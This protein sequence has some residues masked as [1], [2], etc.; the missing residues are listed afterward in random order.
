MRFPPLHVALAFTLIYAPLSSAAQPPTFSINDYGAVSDGK[1][2]NTDAI[3]K[4]IDAASQAGGGTVKV[5]SG[6]WLTGA[7]ELKSNVTLFLDNGSTLLMSTNPADYPVVF[8]RWEGIEC[9]NYS[10]L[11]HAN[12]AS[13]IAITGKGIIDGQGQSWWRW[14]KSAGPAQ[15]KLREMGQMNV[16]PQ[17]RVFGTPKD[18][19]RPSLIEFTYCEDV[20][21]EGVSVKNSPM[22]SIHPLYCKTVICRDLYVFSQGPNTDGIDPDSCNDVLIE[23]CTLDCGD[24]CIA[25]KSGRDADGGRVDTPC[26]NIIIKDCHMQ[27]GHGG[28]AI[29]SEMSGGVRNV[30]ASHCFMRGT[31]IGVRIKTMRGRGGVVEG[32][33]LSDLKMTDIVDEA[34]SIDMEYNLT[35]PKPLDESTPVLRKITL[36][37]II[38]DNAKQAVKLRGLAESEIQ[39]LTIKNA[40]FKTEKGIT[41]EYLDKSKMENIE[42]T[43]SK[44]GPAFMADHV[45]DW[46]LDHFKANRMH[47]ADPLLVFKNAPGLMISHTNAPEHTE[48]FL[49]LRGADTKNVNLIE[50]DVSKAKQKLDLGEEVPND[51]VNE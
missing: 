44:V 17:K 37:D 51:A 1:T 36:R 38:C 28:I 43:L 48:V 20:R 16:D 32:V 25:I 9:Y 22:W 21:I 14:V 13:H 35:D 23:N 39:N 26:E 49:R 11:I 31:N 3:A 50:C 33:D 18:A 8:T 12:N 29:G 30:T 45:M 46:S 24:D 4:A 15:R 47:K 27:R 6:K 10:G 34:I 42:V 5:L 40:K 41:A 19:L 2:L 7:V